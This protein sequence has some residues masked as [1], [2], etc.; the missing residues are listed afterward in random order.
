MAQRRR[1]SLLS[2]RLRGGF[3]ASSLP[4]YSSSSSG[5]VSE[6]S[7]PH[8]SD[9]IHQSSSLQEAEGIDNASVMT[10][11]KSIHDKLGALEEK[12]MKLTDA[13]K[14]LNGIVRKQEKDSFTIKGSSLEVSYACCHC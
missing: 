2:G 1:P 6:D 9:Y 4:S 8:L 5:G 11:L 7:D 3:L 13:F 14:E 12:H 10:M